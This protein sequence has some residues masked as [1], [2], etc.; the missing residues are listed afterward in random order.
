MHPAKILRCTGCGN[1]IVVS[2]GID[3]P[4]HCIVCQMTGTLSTLIPTILRAVP[5]PYQFGND[6]YTEKKDD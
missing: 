5:K 6:S 2:K 1:K 3:S 4:K